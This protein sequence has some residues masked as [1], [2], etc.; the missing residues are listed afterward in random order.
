MNEYLCPIRRKL[1]VATLILACVFAA[2]WVRSLFVDDQYAFD[3][4]TLYSRRGEFGICRYQLYPRFYGLTQ[5]VGMT[6]KNVFVIPY[7][8]VATPLLLVSTFLLLL[9]PSAQQQIDVP[10]STGTPR[11]MSSLNNLPRR[12]TLC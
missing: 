1:G 7:P 2:G 6:T 5:M 8:A 4:H 12:R 9:K 11:S 10:C 3:S